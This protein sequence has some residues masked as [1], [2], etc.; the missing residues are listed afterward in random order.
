M[1]EPV[2]FIGGSADGQR[3]FFD[4]PLQRIDVQVMK[5]EATW[6]D[7]P[8]RPPV[9][10]ETYYRVFLPYRMRDCQAYLIE[11]ESPNN[12]IPLLI[13]GYRQQKVGA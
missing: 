6:T 10:V 8:E 11:S 2:L 9:T 12:L 4:R 5:G 1:T 3:K 13:E 7:S